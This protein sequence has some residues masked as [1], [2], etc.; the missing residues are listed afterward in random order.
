MLHSQFNYCDC[1]LFGSYQRPY[2]AKP[3]PRGFHERSVT[4]SL[5]PAWRAHPRARPGARRRRV[6]AAGDGRGVRREAGAG[7]PEAA[8]DGGQPGRDRVPRGRDREAP[9]AA[10][11]AH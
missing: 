10:G 3:D 2:S 4:C 9:Q 8:A 11:E 6:R 7:S 5:R 1:R